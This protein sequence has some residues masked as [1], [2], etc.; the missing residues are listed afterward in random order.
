M[1]FTQYFSE[2]VKKIKVIK[3]ENSLL[4]KL[5]AF[6]LNLLTVIKIIDFPKKKF[7]TSYDTTLWS[8]IYVSGDFEQTSLN[9][10][11][12]ELSHV[13]QFREFWMPIK[14][15]FSRRWRARYEAQASQAYMALCPEKINDQFI[16]GQAMLLTS[17]GI[18][19]DIATQELQTAKEEAISKYTS[20]EA[21]KV[22]LAFC[23][24][25]NSPCLP[26]LRVWE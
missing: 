10:R 4:M 3:K 14:Y 13:I 7:M 23:R 21:M 11:L 9:H 22:F 12:H 18:P 16:Q 26:D 8:R 19:L 24:W 15:F 1:S 2:N 20:N 5:I 17:Y 6:F 25:K